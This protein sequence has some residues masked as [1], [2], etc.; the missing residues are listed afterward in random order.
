[1]TKYPFLN[2]ELYKL[3]VNDIQTIIAAD[4]SPL[5]I[6]EELQKSQLEYEDAIFDR[7]ENIN[8]YYDI[9]QNIPWE[10]LH[11]RVQGINSELSQQEI[12]DTFDLM[13]AVSVFFN[14]IKCKHIGNTILS[15]TV[16]SD[17]QK[18]F[19][20]AIEKQ[21]FKIVLA[22]EKAKSNKKHTPIKVQREEQLIQKVVEEWIAEGKPDVGE[23]IEDNFDHYHQYVN[24]NLAGFIEKN[25]N[26]V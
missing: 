20:E 24:S 14:Q 16:I 2:E 7:A 22:E 13:R 9:D 25:R 6:I 8:E 17:I 15:V 1:M 10:V 3:I 23:F 26:C 19:K 18:L 4:Q 12:P 21:N 5:K 11:E